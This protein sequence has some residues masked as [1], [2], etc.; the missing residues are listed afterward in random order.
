MTLSTSVTA[1]NTNFISASLNDFESDELFLISIDQI[2]DV[3]FIINTLSNKTFAHRLIA[4]DDIVEI[5]IKFISYSYITS[6]ESRYDDREFKSL[7]IDSDAVRKSIENIKQFKTLQRIN[8]V[9]LN[10]SD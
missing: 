7:L 4:K 1:L 8:D 6:S 5:L 10:K 9:K 3:E 2:D